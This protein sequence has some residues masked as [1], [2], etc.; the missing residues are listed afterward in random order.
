MKISHTGKLPPPMSMNAL[1]HQYTGPVL[2]CQGAL[3]PLNDA[4]SRAA[5]FQI[6]RD[7]NNNSNKNSNNSNNSNSNKNSNNSNN[8]N[9]NKNSNNSSNSNSNKEDSQEDGSHNG[10][11]VDLLELGHCP[12]DENAV[13]VSLSMKTWMRNNN[14]LD[15]FI[16]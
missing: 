14:I 15:K 9:S 7:S 8:S 12:M 2:I 11:T 10:I 13:L 16:S 1:L 5:M 4:K 3:D 6:V